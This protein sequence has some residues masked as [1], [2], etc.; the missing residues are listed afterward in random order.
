MSKFGKTELRDSPKIL[1]AEI[2]LDPGPP[3]A[4]HATWVCADKGVCWDT[5]MF[6]QMHPPPWMAAALLACSSPGKVSLSQKV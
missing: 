4:P 1:V 6:A 2:G 5:G 3:A